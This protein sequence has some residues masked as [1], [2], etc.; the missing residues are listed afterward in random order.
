MHSNK[1]FSIIEL[2][3]V[4]AIIGILVAVATPYYRGYVIKAN[5]TSMITALD[6]CREIATKD[7]IKTDNFP[8]PISCF[9]N[10][11]SGS[12]GTAPAGFN[13]VYYER[14]TTSNNEPM[15]HM[16]ITKSGVPRSDGSD[17]GRLYIGMYYNSQEDTLVTSCGN[18]ANNSTDIDPNYL[19][20]TCQ[21]QIAITIWSQ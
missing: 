12:T 3:I 16:Y 19:P 5:V 2:M 20:S 7:F 9:G 11:T 14:G 13:A 15:M 4:L 1:A 17:F 8:S 18:W 6:S 10:V 21:D